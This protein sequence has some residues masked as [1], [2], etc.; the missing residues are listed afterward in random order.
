[1]DD[2]LR[3]LEALKPFAADDWQ[4]QILALQPSDRRKDMVHVQPWA[5]FHIITRK[6]A[7]YEVND[8]SSGETAQ[9]SCS[10][11]N[12]VLIPPLAYLRSTQLADYENL[13]FVL[14]GDSL[15]IGLATAEKNQPQKKYPDYVFHI[16]DSLQLATVHLFLAFIDSGNTDFSGD[17]TRFL[18]ETV[19]LLIKAIY[20]DLERS[21]ELSLDNAGY[22]YRNVIEY[23]NKHY[24]SPLSRSDVGQAMR[25]SE[26]YIS[27]LFRKYG[28]CS[29]NSYLLQLRLNKAELLLKNTMLSVSEIAFSC[30]FQTTSF[31]IKRFRQHYGLTP[32]KYRTSGAAGAE[33]SHSAAN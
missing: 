8:N 2:R 32:A 5:R 26:S 29:F 31:F 1:M 27:K 20:S 21:Q 15:R 23:V 12:V 11:G 18:Q 24:A 16:E 10:C 17:K 7:I 33:C 22:S 19:K 28:N 13:F 9:L 4:P 30:G 14:R 6:T 3:L 25:L